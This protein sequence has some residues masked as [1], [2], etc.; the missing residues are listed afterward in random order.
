MKK[1]ALVLNLLWAI[2]A[3]GT[4]YAGIKWNGSRPQGSAS[5][6]AAKVPVTP[7]LPAITSLGTT[8]KATV[9]SRDNDVLDFFKRYGLGEGVP[10]SPEAMKMAISEALRE[11]NPIK[12]QM[13][14]ARL[15]EELTADNAPSVL[16]ML[17]E[18]VAGF[19]SMRFMGMLGYAW[20]QVDPKAAME[21]MASSGDRGGR[22]SQTSVLSGWASTDPKGATAWLDAYEGDDKQWLTQS[23][24]SGLAKSDFEAA[25]KYA[26]AIQDEGERTRS[27]ETL[28]RELIKTGGVEKAAAWFASLTD[29]RMKSGAFDTVIQ[30]LTRS[31]PDR[32][33]E[34][35]KQHA[36]E[37]FARGAAGSLAQELA[38]KDIQKGLEF[39]GSLTGPAQARA[40]GQIVNE[41]MDRDEGAHS[42][43]ASQF[44]GSLPAG[45]GRD[46]GAAAIA[47]RVV[48][49]D[50]E[51]AIAWASSIQD[52]Q[53]REEAL[54]ETARRYMRQ[55]S[56]AATAWLAQSGLSAEAQQQVT[57]PRG[58]FR[59]DFRGGFQGGGRG[60]RGG[61]PPGG[62]GGGGPGGGGRRGGR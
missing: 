54:I 21:Q 19:D 46:A 2:V 1:S 23:L 6:P 35:V 51:A 11:S 47:R 22:M 38:R 3:A 49:D 16:A 60:G 31:D 43:E 18:N 20:G 32:A 55:D 58:D 39:A 36:G 10:V 12:S 29:E 44:V 50:P 53:N 9:V 8:V 61:G 25:S 56:Q 62:F 41:W 57:A 4:F 27:A 59:G 14:F 33:M 34:F 7:D 52:P 48:G 30:Q 5:R 17:R 37:D 28:A 45:A 42:V 24:V 40:Y 26:A 15:M 13:L